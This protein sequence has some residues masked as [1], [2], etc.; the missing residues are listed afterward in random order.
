MMDRIGEE[1]GRFFL[2]RQVLN[3]LFILT[4]IVGMA[5]YFKAGKDVGTYLLI[6]SCVLKFAE[7]TLRLMKI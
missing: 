2:L 3:T 6:A 1:R 7:V 5:F 4:A